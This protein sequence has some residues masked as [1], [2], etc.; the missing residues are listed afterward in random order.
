MTAL[1]LLASLVLVGCD[2]KA[3]PPTT[4]GGF[5][6]ESL[7]VNTEAE[8]QAVTAVETS[9]VD[10]QYRL[11]VL[12][13]YYNR[14]G[15]A[16][17]YKWTQNE[18]RNL[19]EAQT[20]T[21]RAAPK[22]TPPSGEAIDNVDEQLLVEYLVKS[23]RQYKTAV[24]ELASFYERNGMS[25]QAAMVRNM[26]DRLDP[27]R[28]YYYIIS[29]CIPPADLRPTEVSSEADR[30]YDKG[31]KLYED[32]KG[33]LHTFVTTD[34]QK[35]RRA[36]AC[37]LDLI[38]RY[39]RST[40]IAMSA[41]FIGEI[42]KE[43]FNEDLLAVNWYER[44][45]MWDANL[46]KPARFQAATVWDLRLKNRTRALECYRLCIRHEQFNSSNVSY[47]SYRINELEKGQ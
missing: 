22:V 44:A 25:H 3:S 33:I 36:L 19:A 42:Y 47:A 20:F 26:Q 23:R 13:N 43:Y 29:A 21:W 12:Q 37:F 6:T 2:T 32:G 24:E 9:R 40:K 11:T 1:V 14:V 39:P 10:Y 46:P 41:Y 8:R 45:W 35:Q 30:L 16:D 34:Y 17:K 4:I 15:N 7:N 38:E 28:Q 5:A 27:V 31:V 18:L